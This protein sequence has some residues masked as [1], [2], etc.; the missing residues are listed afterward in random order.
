MSNLIK[1]EMVVQLMDN[2]VLSQQSRLKL[3]SASVNNSAF[4]NKFPLLNS[5]EFETNTLIV[6]VSDA[7]K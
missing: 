5:L 3:E 7:D 2:H 6:Q 4:S 1:I